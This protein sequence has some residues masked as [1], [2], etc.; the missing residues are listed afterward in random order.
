MYSFNTHIVNKST[1]TMV[2]NMEDKFEDLNDKIS[3]IDAKLQAIEDLINVKLDVCYKKVNDVYSMQNKVN[4]ITKMN[5][6]SIIHQIN[7]YDE[8]INDFDNNQKQAIFNSVETS[9]S[10]KGGFDKL[11]NKCF[12]KHNIK[13]QDKEMFYMSSMNKNGLN[14]KNK[15]EMTNLSETSTKPEQLKISVNY[16]KN[17]N[18]LENSSTSS[19]IKSSNSKKKSLSENNKTNSSTSKITK[20]STKDTTTSHEKINDSNEDNIFT[21]LYTNNKK[22]NLRIIKDNL[23]LEND[24]NLEHI[25]NS[26][27]ENIVD[28]FF[29]K[30]ISG[31]DFKEN[32][33][34]VILE[35]NSSTVKPYKVETKSPKFAN[36]MKI[37][38]E[39]NIIKNN[40]Y[41]KLNEFINNS[42]RSSNKS[43]TSS[44]NTSNTKSNSNDSSN[45]SNDNDINDFGQTFQF[46]NITEFNTDNVIFANLSHSQNKTK[47]IELN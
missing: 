45:D 8:E 30:K 33:G 5:N 22:G 19:N 3:D 23:S 24:S 42:D 44:Q 31:S 36:A 1:A 32:N 7:Q 46:A 2:D 35:M 21:N 39:T 34:T 43:T 9:M 40:S 14:S 12:I 4:E 27:P 15:T 16:L 25:I 37:L 11:N 38:N 18:N 17:L 47:I 41:N 13:N 29:E 26:L 10:P 20:E 6:Q 28:N